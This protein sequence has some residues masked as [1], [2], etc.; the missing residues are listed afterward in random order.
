MPKYSAEQM[1]ESAMA[2]YNN[3]DKP[4][5]ILQ[6]QEALALKP[7]YDQA[8]NNRGNFLLQVGN[9]FD[10]VLNYERAITIRDAPEYHNN[11]GAAL[12]E[13]N[14]WPEAEM[15]YREATKRRPKFEHALTNLGNVLKL[16]DRVPEARKVYEEAIEANKDYVDAHL[17]LSFAALEQGDFTVGWRE[18][19]WRW[20]SN[21]LPPRGLP[22]PEWRGTNLQDQQGL[23]LYAEQGMGDALQFSRYASLIKEKFGGRVYVEVRPALA[24]IMRTLKN[25]DGVVPF[26]DAVPADA[27]FCCPLM[28][29]PLIFGTQVETIPATRQYLWADPH[30]VDSFTKEIA[31]L[32]KNFLIGVCWAGE[33]RLGNPGASAIDRRR[34]TTLAAL[35]P[36]AVI[37]GISWVSLQKGPPSEQIKAPP[38]GM[39]ILDCMDDCDDW[40]DTAALIQHL[41][42]VISVDTSV[43]HLAAALG[44]PTWIL[45]RKDACWRWMGDRR[46]SP[47]YPT[48]THYRMKSQNDWEGLIGEVSADLREVVKAHHTNVRAA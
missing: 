21:Q 42:M 41:D 16:M 3:G 2:H 19:E 45:S 22:L 30:R 6:M 33:N 39:T 10:A 48:V 1:Y 7:D 15:A 26:G 23:I 34:S 13:L 24:R 35:S 27:Q 20:K 38:R 17:N 31:K 28:T 14:R 5:A 36:L 18:Y 40:Y 37:P 32:P 44:K 47:W 43:A 46:D 12:A 11:R 25:I 4:T 9:A 29:C 8:W